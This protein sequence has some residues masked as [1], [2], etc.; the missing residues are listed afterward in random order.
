MSRGL[1]KSP[2]REKVAPLLTHS[3]QL[4]AKFI[5]EKKKVPGSI[6]QPG[7]FQKD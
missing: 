3:A 7:S 6:L 1:Q 2:K 4:S 5:P